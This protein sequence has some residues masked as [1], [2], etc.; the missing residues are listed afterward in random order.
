MKGQILNIKTSNNKTYK[1]N[2]DSCKENRGDDSY[3]GVSRIG[4][5][6]DNNDDLDDD[7]DYLSVGIGGNIL[8]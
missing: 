4:I 1:I 3:V 6:L 8:K 7:S 2:F 5:I